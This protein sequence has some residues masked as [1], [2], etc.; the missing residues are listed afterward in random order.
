MHTTDN[1]DL[2]EATTMLLTARRKLSG[3]DE[4]AKGY[5]NLQA[6][7]EAATA[8][9][10]AVVKR[11]LAGLERRLAEAERQRFIQRFNGFLATKGGRADWTPECG[12]P[13]DA[14]LQ[15]YRPRMIYN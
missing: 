3:T 13:Q 12:E 1:T 10:Q 5:A 15:H 11:D 4:L 7:V 8:H 14:T 6:G 2:A 9:W